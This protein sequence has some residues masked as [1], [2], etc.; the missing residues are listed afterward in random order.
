MLDCCNCCIVADDTEGSRLLYV[1]VLSTLLTF[2]AMASLVKCYSACTCVVVVVFILLCTTVQLMSLPC[3][4]KRV[5]WLITVQG[6]L[7]RHA[8][9][10]L[11]GTN[12]DLACPVTPPR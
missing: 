2:Q 6:L 3:R 1:Q 10:V 5:Q 7:S 8:L 12:L 9:H 4:P 11:G